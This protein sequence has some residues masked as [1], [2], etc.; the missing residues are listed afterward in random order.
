MWSVGGATFAEGGE[1][2]GRGGEGGGAGF[3]DVEDIEVAAGA[4]LDLR[5]GFFVVSRFVAVFDIVVPISASRLER[6]LGE[7]KGALPPAGSLAS[8]RKLALV[9][10]PSTDEMYGLNFGA[11]GKGEG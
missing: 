4:G 9:A 8:E 1:R 7:A 5:A 11:G 3:G 10:V 2:S 6:L